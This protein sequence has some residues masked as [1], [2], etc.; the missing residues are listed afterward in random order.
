[1]TT[2]V[3]FATPGALFLTPVPP[4]S[5]LI[6]PLFELPPHSLSSLILLNA[7]N[8]LT[9]PV[10]LLSLKLPARL[11]LFFPPVKSTGEGGRDP[12]GE[13][14]PVKAKFDS[15]GVAKYAVGNPGDRTGIDKRGLTFEGVEIVGGDD[16]SGED[17]GVMG[18]V[19][20]EGV[21]E[22][23]T[24]IGKVVTF[25]FGVWDLDVPIVRPITYAT[26]SWLIEG[27]NGRMLVGRKERGMGKEETNE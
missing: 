7:I 8:P 14:S 19:G 17:G 18:V 6:V 26:M 22:S 21:R 24:D 10:L 11:L 5:S 1:V 13:N 12:G 25:S 15:E 20:D 27:L 9:L 16:V 2:L 3:I 23:V 4:P